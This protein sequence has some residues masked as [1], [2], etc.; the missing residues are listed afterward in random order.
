MNDQQNVITPRVVLQVLFFVVL[1]PFLPLLI[2]GRWNWWEAWLY[3]IISILSFVISRILAARRHPDL[4]AERARMMQHEDAEPWDR[5]LAPLLGLSGALALLVAGLDARYNW[6]QDF[7][8]PLK[9]IALIVILAGNILGTYALMEN[10]F[11]SGVVRLQTDR[12]QHVVSS[13]PYRWVCNPGYAGALLTYWGAP[14]FLG[15]LW[16]FIPVMFITVIL[17]VRTNLEDNTLQEK[18]DGYREYAGR[19]RYRLLP[20]VW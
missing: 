13:C 12:G 15:S 20:G 1:L 6:S 11:F 18:L 3:A 19:V 7:D 8:M 10:R 17:V 14:I 16:M 5:R 2:S 9:I 4:I